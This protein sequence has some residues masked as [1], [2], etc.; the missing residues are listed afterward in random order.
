MSKKTK[1]PARRLVIAREIE[2]YHDQRHGVMLHLRRPTTVERAA[3]EQDVP[4]YM[5]AC[6]AVV[7]LRGRV[8]GEVVEINAREVARVV[9]FVES[10]LLGASD[11]DTGAPVEL[12][13]DYVSLAGP[14]ALFSVVTHVQLELLLLDAGSSI[15]QL[16]EATSG[17]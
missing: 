13:S 17:D 15:K 2:P 1:K 14:G 5:R 3:F 10:I 9:E 8:T 4:G 6:D 7:R 16:I 11:P 12:P